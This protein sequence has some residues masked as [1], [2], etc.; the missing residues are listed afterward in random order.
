M[1]SAMRIGVLVIAL[2]SVL[3]VVHVGAWGVT[4][5][6]VNERTYEGR[7]EA[8]LPQSL[9]LR[10]EGAI[11]RISRVQ[12]TRLAFG[13]DGVTV[14][15]IGEETFQ[16]QLATELP[17][18][19]R[20]AT[21]SATIEV[22]YAD[23]TALTFERPQSLLA[24]FT[25]PLTVGIGMSK[26]SIP[27]VGVQD[28]MSPIPDRVGTWTP[29]MIWEVP[30]AREETS[31]ASG[32]YDVPLTETRTAVRLTV[33]FN[34]QDVKIDASRAKLSAWQLTGDYLH[35]FGHRVFGRAIAVGLFIGERRNF[36]LVQLN[37]YVSAGLGL[38]AGS[39]G[40]PV[41]RPFATIE[42]RVGGGLRINVNVS[43]VSIHGGAQ[44]RFLPG[45]LM[46]GEGLHGGLN[47]QAGLVFNF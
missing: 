40:P 32:P 21:R 34:L 2:V 4:V 10:V 43:N 1:R 9:A 13:D 28:S 42:A 25:L 38:A 31:L 17:G 19:L 26:R 15:T 6:T 36:A 5:H 45:P 46:G 14:T 35:Y 29:T 3:S 24:Q 27:L 16:G 39:V 20:L 22:P 23:I 47:L 7:I 8:G 41:G 44:F 37:P 30:L 12:I 33:G 11:V 18:A